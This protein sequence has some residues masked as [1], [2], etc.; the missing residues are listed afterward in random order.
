MHCW[1]QH[2]DP[3]GQ[4]YLRE[5]CSSLSW[6]GW[7]TEEGGCCWGS[8]GRPEP[9][10]REFACRG[11]RR[12][13]QA[14]PG[15]GGE[16]PRGRTHPREDERVL[17]SLPSSLGG[18]MEPLVYDSSSWILACES[19]S[20]HQWEGRDTAH[21]FVTH[22]AQ[23]SKEIEPRTQSWNTGSQEQAQTEDG[24]RICQCSPFNLSCKPGGLKICA[25]IPMPTL[26]FSLEAQG[27]VVIWE[28]WNWGL[29]ENV[30]FS[31]G[32]ENNLNLDSFP[33]SCAK[34]TTLIFRNLKN[35]P[36]ILVTK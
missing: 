3:R 30:L 6:Q 35:W 7:R 28:T 20:G 36:V 4:R 11:E 2:E 34:A 5:G 18:G 19:C 16:T 21:P 9:T 14:I 13:W 1:Q 22:R 15:M 17:L 8:D 29:G 32:K 23:P 10:G 12:G 27:W 31:L 25:L 24:S 33:N 26:R